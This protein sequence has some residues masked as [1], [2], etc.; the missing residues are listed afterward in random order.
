MK[1]NS[2]ASCGR[3]DNLDRTAVGQTVSFSSDSR[4][5][6]RTVD[7]LGSVLRV[8]GADI[9]SGRFRILL[10]RFLTR[11]VPVVSACIWTWVRL[12][13]APGKYVI[14]GRGSG[15]SER[16][17]RERL[18]RLND[19][20][21]IDA[22]GNRSGAVTL[23]P[24][25]FVS[26]YRDGLFGGFLTVLKDGSGI[27]GFV[28]VDPAR[29]IRS[30]DKKPH[31]QLEINGRKVDLNRTDFYYLPF[32]NSAS[33]PFGRSILQSVPFVSYVEQQLVD[34]M[35]RSSH[36][37]GYHRLHV[38]ITPPERMTGE[39]DSAYTDRINRYF[40]DTIDM[41]RSCDIEDNPVTWN[42]VAIEYIGPSKSRE[43]ANSWFMTHRAM[44]EDI[45][46]GTSLSPY[47]LGYSYGATTTW[48]AFKF[49]I[50]MRQVRSVQAEVARFMEW[51]GKI[52]LALAGIDAT[53]RYRFDNAFAYQAMDQSAIETGHID[54]I[55]KL[56]NA[57][58]I[59]ENTARAKAG[60]LL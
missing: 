31:L 11:N 29:I 42:N 39:S 25:L 16:K 27:D 54:N 14:D 5:P 52:E 24:D 10:Y 37:S 9:E 7:K 33:D 13:A 3:T 49:D 21:Y 15:T 8:S 46:A 36:N 4:S 55:L 34:D 51:M 19:R 45:C 60:E 41:I 1:T 53:C 35:R 48:S 40:D 30:D 58:L 2:G 32:N 43:V 38:K 47:L 57:G 44:V 28:P 6:F 56:Y 20:L 18:N 26:L 59:D 12:S 50:V 22:L 17:A 23:L